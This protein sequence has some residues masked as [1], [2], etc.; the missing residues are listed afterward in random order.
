MPDLCKYIF[1]SFSPFHEYG[2]FIIQ[3]K[4]ISNEL[5]N[6][7]THILYMGFIHYWYW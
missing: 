5:E 4:T 1:A 6:Y 2:L 3:S 7:K